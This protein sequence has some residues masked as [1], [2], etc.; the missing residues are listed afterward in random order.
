MN[1]P[2]CVIFVLLILLAGTAVLTAQQG[3]GMS[4]GDDWTDVHGA[5]AQ[6]SDPKSGNP[7]DYA[8]GFGPQGDARRIYNMVRAVRSF[9]TA[10]LDYPVVGTNQAA[11]YDDSK[12]VTDK[13]V[14]YGQDAD[15]SSLAPSYT[16]NGDGTVTD[17]NTGLRWQRDPGS[18]MGWDEALK[19][20]EGS[21]LAGY[22]DWRIPTI[23]EL[24]SLIDFSGVDVDPSASD[25]ESPFINTEYFDFVYG[26]TSKGERIIDSQFMSS[27]RYVSTT[28]HGNATVFGVNFADGRIK[29]YPESD[30]RSG[31]Q[32][33]FFV[34]LVRGNENYGINNFVDNGDG[35]VSDL[36]T[37]LMW[38]KDDSGKGLNWKEALDYCEDLVYAGYDDWRLPDAKELESIVDYSRSP[39]TTNSAAVDPVFNSTSIVNEAGEV[40][41]GYYWSSTTHVSASARDAGSQAVYVSFGRAIGNLAKFQLPGQQGASG[42]MNG[43]PSGQRPPQQKPPQGQMMAPPRR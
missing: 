36:A 10:D 3:M 41:F 29:G 30:P 42:G 6:R 8:G 21:A 13:T 9:S 11:R 12:A 43:Q 4:R 20:A 17:N 24:Y 7:A 23:K 22:S 19:A 31:E 5:G 39:D 18:K 14:F 27:T 25:A 2:V 34:L 35:T 15:Y 26:D 40:D 37:G 16:D 38:M 1:R 32:K 28:M 33:G